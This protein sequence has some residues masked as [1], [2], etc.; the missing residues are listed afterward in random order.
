MAEIIQNAFDVNKNFH[1]LNLKIPLKENDDML[2]SLKNFE[3]SK[4]T[5]QEEVDKDSYLK[6]KFDKFSNLDLT[7]IGFT[8]F[9]SKTS[10]AK[11][12][13]I[14]DW[15]A[16]IYTYSAIKNNLRFND[17]T[18]LEMISKDKEEK[19]KIY[20]SFIQQIKDFIAQNSS[21]RRCVV[22]FASHFQDYVQSQT[23][24]SFDADVSCLLYI[25]YL[26]DSVR[27]VF[28]AIDMKD[29]A[30]V[31][32]MLLYNFFIKPVYNDKVD[33]SIYS[34]TVQNINSLLPFVTKVIS[35]HYGVQ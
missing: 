27:L 11:A 20:N 1:M 22:R 9:K 3:L 33:I 29:E 12:D 28:R 8:D 34:S 13:L 31:D 10:L 16:T 21:S 5:I 25:H 15:T 4:E 18:Y 26:K 32:L 24:A 17:K 2:L 7:S 35:I 23:D 14:E 30:F 19:I 6:L